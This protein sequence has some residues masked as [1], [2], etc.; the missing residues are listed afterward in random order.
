M[1]HNKGATFSALRDL[2]R[3]ALLWPFFLKPHKLNENYLFRSRS[4]I[5]FL[6]SRVLSRSEENPPLD[7]ME[8][9]VSPLATSAPRRAQPRSVRPAGSDNFDLIG[10]TSTGA[11][12]ATG[13]APGSFVK[14]SPVWAP[15][16]S[17]R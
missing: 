1:Y 8:V 14:K 6:L 13:A 9:F 15:L 10:G 11:I 4:L 17:Y 2:L 12:I 16:P 5:R 7:G 3:S